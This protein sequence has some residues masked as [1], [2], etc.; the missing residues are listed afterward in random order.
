[1]P[2]D[3]HC[4]VSGA[5]MAEEK[6]KFLVVAGYFMLRAVICRNLDERA[7]SPNLKR[8]IKGSRISFYLCRV[9]SG[10]RGISADSE[11]ESE[12]GFASEISVMR[13]LGGS[14]A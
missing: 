5:A 11:T 7:F 10:S 9:C 1:M 13:N 2:G 8:R 6:D 4:G 3:C 14:A 12:R